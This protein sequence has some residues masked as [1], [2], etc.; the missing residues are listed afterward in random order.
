L[1]APRKKR[2]TRQPRVKIPQIGFTFAKVL[3][4]DTIPIDLKRTAESRIATPSRKKSDH[5]PLSPF[6]K[7]PTIVKVS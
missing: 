6:T 2:E 3:M 5:L 1:N 7:E 4:S